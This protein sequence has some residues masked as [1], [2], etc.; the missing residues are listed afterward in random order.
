MKIVMLGISVITFLIG[1]NGCGSSDS[2]VDIK[3][4]E[5]K[6]N[7]YGGVTVP[8]IYVTSVVDSVT[9]KDVLVN[10]G[11]CRMSFNTEFPYNLKYGEKYATSGVICNV[12]QV[13]VITDQ[14]TWTN[15]FK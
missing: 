3:V 4:V 2:P 5:A 1:L 10:K 15:N 6:S 7:L 12:I 14:G 8:T 9:I 11:N 13:D